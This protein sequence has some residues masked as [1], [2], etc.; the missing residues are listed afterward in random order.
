MFHNPQPIILKSI[1]SYPFSVYYIRE[2]SDHFVYMCKTT[3]LEDG[4]VITISIVIYLPEYEANSV[5]KGIFRLDF[6]LLDVHKDNNFICYIDQS[7]FD[8]HF[9]IAKTKFNIAIL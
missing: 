1:T 5:S 4:T 6:C 7:V 8:L 3:F 2:Q 9:E